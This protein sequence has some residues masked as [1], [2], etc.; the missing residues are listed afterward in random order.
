MAKIHLIGVNGYIGSLVRNYLVAAGHLVE[1]ASYRLPNIP[2]KSINADFIIHL[3]ASG[4]GTV[5]NPRKGYCDHE[6]MRNVN[7]NGMRSLISGI[8]NPETK[9]FFI[10][11]TSVY[12]KFT[13]SPL[14]NES[15]KLEPVSIYGEHKVASEKILQES[16]FDWLIL[17]PCGVFGPSAE[18]RFGNSFLNVL[19]AKAISK[20]QITLLGGDQKIDTLYLLDLIHIILRICSG[21]WHSR[22][23][24]NVAGEIVTLETMILSLVQTIQRMGIPCSVN[25]KDNPGKPAILADATKLRKAFPGWEPTPFNVSMHSLV[26][27]YLSQRDFD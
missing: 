9:V 15:S 3:A 20:G 11:S 27:A 19:T 13:H 5:H 18:Y 1:I 14:V 2:K 8:K 4:G 22:E 23:V 26:S 10:S 21:E 17:R 24:Y 12:G 6:L 25:K 7:I 16:D